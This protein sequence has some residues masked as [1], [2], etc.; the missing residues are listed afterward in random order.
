MHVGIAHWK[1]LADP[2]RNPAAAAFFH[3]KPPRRAGGIPEYTMPTNSNRLC[4]FPRLNPAR[5]LLFTLLLATAAG[6]PVAMGQAAQPP[7]N[8]VSPAPKASPIDAKVSVNFPGGTVSEYVAALKANVKESPVN[9][10]MQ[11]GVELVIVPRIEL[12]RVSLTTALNILDFAEITRRDEDLYRPLH[13]MQVDEDTAAPVW[14]ISMQQTP[15]SEQQSQGPGP[16][17]EDLIP[18]LH[19]FGVSD[20]L[21]GEG[22]MSPE[23]LLTAIKVA[24]EL[25]FPGQQ[26]PELRLHRETGTLVLRAARGQ[27]RAIESLVTNLSVNTHQRRRELQATTRERIEH[28]HRMRMSQIS[29]QVAEERIAAAERRRSHMEQLQQAG[30]A[31]DSELM[32][33]NDVVETARAEFMKRQADVE[34]LHQLVTHLYAERAKLAP[35]GGEQATIAALREEVAQLKAQVQQLREQA[36]HK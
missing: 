28:E 21:N 36:Q 34:H 16:A 26:P 2:R 9:V 30:S 3:Q 20:I 23:D 6:C 7:V 13:V 35:A 5:T 10:V 17:S 24:L 4:P 8:A 19:I 31:S 33:A 18:T 11:R 15:S 27:V 32:A 12:D 29:L 14:V 25:S 1:I 22:A